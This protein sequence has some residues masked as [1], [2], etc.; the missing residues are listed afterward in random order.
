MSSS[1]QAVVVF[2][3]IALL[4]LRRDRWHAIRCHRWSRVQGVYRRCVVYSFVWKLER[5]ARRLPVPRR[6]ISASDEASVVDSIV[7]AGPKTYQRKPSNVAQIKALLG[8][9][10][11][12]LRR[13]R[14]PATRRVAFLDLGAGKALLTR[15]CYEASGRRAPAIALDCRKLSPYDR[16]Y[17]PPNTRYAREEAPD[18]DGEAPYSRVIADVRRLGATKLPVGERSRDGGVL[19]LSKHLCGDATDASLV[20]VCAEPLAGSVG[21]CVIAPCCHQKMKQRHYCNVAY[22]RSNGFCR[23]PRAPDFA[24][25]L[26]LVELSKAKEL[27]AFE[28]KR[29]WILPLLGFPYCR[30]LGKI[31]RRLLEGGRIAYLEARGFEAELVSYVDEDVAPD[32][33]AIIATRPLAW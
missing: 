9:V 26:H 31:A 20:A 8:C 4:V 30:R 2:A 29:S 32:N 6:V 24:T 7:D 21:A 15:A 16:L 5:A 14:R 17:D 22:L 1:L 28:Y 13:V 25:L 27:Q 18:V 11:C 19:A 12:V 10:R 3:A 33:L 23:D